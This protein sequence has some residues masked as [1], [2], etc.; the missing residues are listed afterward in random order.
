MGK[1][2][3]NL[4]KAKELP[5]VS[6]CTPTF[7]RRPFIPYMIKCFEHQT[8]PKDKIE[9]IIIDDGS[10]KIED[11]VKDIPQVKYFYYEDKMYLGKKRN[12]MHSK[13]SGDIIIYMDDDDYYPPERIS[14]VV[15]SFQ[16]NPKYILAGS[17][18]MHIYFSSRNEIYQCGPYRENHATAATF[19]FKKEL[20]LQT[21]YNNDVAFAEEKLFLKDYSIPMIQLNTLHTIFVVSHKHNSLDK[22]KLLENP[23]QTKVKPSRYTID[24]FIKDPELKQFYIYDMKNILEDYELGK[25]KYKLGL[26]EQL[27]TM[28]ERR[29]NMQNQQIIQQNPQLFMNTLQQN[30]QLIQQTLQ[31]NPQLLHMLVQSNPQILQQIMINNNSIENV[32]REYENK[33]NTKNTLIEQLMNKVKFLTD[34]NNKLKNNQG[35]VEN[36]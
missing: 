35:K 31:Q 33:I 26:V 17:S 34:E 5:L 1:N 18:E 15:D 21:S 3:K 8:Y 6:L 30:P 28:E 7:N 36:S 22:E 12:L 14:H 23:G 25:Q 10:D 9:W 4:N 29:K 27:Q 11:L 20:L 32:K 13:C 2:K 19:A 24:E 16:R